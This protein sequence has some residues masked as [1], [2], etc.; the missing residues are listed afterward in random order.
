MTATLP[1]VVVIGAGFTGAATAH[2]L[3]LRGFQVT[4]VERGEITSGTSGR[5]HCLLHSG[6]RYCVKDQEAASECIDENFILRKIMPDVLELNDGLFVAFDEADLVFQEKF[7]QGCESCHIPFQVL[8]R[9]QTLALEPNLTPTLLGAVRVPDGVFEALRFAL[10][11]L[12]TARKNGAQVFTYHQVVDLLRDGTGTVAGVRVVDRARREMK[13]IPADIVVNATGPWVGEI[14]ALAGIAVPIVPTPGVMISLNKRVCNLV[15]NKMNKP[16]DGDIIVPQRQSS[17]IGTTSWVTE[18]A[19][20]IPIPQDH[21]KLM[22]ERGAAMSPILGQAQMR[23]A[24]AVARPLIGSA[25]AGDARELSRTF[26]C[27]DHAKQ[28]IEGFVTITGGKATTARA[29]AEKT[30]DI[31]CRKL[32][33]DVPC[34]T[35]D[36]PLISYR[37]YYAQ[38]A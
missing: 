1:R 4:V 27:F 38:A 37:R 24:F 26:E 32:G 13:D 35:K 12:S 17:L 6:G 10:T 16:S 8:T 9:Q 18:S 11:F 29:M 2:D 28:G 21:V 36:T 20:Y 19:D 14:T 22:R 31:V 23:G 15:I 25:S 7:V 30:V 5:C 33:I 3:A 34:R